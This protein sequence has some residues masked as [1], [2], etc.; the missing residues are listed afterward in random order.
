MHALSPDRPSSLGVENFGSICPSC[1]TTTAIKVAC[2]CAPLRTHQVSTELAQLLGSKHTYN[3]GF[4]ILARLPLCLSAVSPTEVGAAPQNTEGG[5]NHGFRFEVWGALPTFNAT[6][7][8]TP[9]VYKPAPPSVAFFRISS[10]A[11]NKHQRHHHHLH[12]HYRHHNQLYQSYHRHSIGILLF[13]SGLLTRLEHV[14]CKRFFTT[15][16]QAGSLLLSTQSTASLIAFGPQTN[17]SA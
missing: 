4:A 12:R 15:D 17:V 7:S 14:S 9:R 5:I 2:L 6:I 3:T 1:P 11:S 10:R 16:T 13:V 8:P